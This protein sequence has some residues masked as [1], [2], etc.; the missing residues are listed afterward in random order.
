MAVF[1]TLSVPAAAGLIATQTIGEGYT[2]PLLIGWMVIVL[3]TSILAFCVLGNAV[4][5]FI[6]RPPR[7][8]PRRIAEASLV[9]GCVAIHLAVAFHDALWPVFGDG[10]L[11]SVPAVA[12]LTLGAGLVTSLVVAALL[13]ARATRSNP[14]LPHAQ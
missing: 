8:R 4:A 7:S 9:A 6:A 13:L 3:T 2:N 12:V 11:R 5:G 14:P 1:V 10:P